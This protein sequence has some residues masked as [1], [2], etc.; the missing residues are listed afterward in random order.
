MQYIH[1]TL[2]SVASGEYN[3]GEFFIKRPAGTGENGKMGEKRC[4]IGD[5]APSCVKKMLVFIAFICGKM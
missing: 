5:F 2:E 1:R 4:V 3:S